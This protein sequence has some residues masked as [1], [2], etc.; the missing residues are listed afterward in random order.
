M[1]ELIKQIRIN[2]K[3]IDNETYNPSYILHNLIK[4]NYHHNIY[5]KY[6]LNKLHL[7]I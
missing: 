4:L 7:I 2:R 6:K 5:V 3:D 1:D